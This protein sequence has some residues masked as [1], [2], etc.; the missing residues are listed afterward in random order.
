[1]PKKKDGPHDWSDPPTNWAEEQ[2]HRVALEI[3]RLR[4]KRP[5]QWLA[6]KTKELGSPVTRSVIS[7]M[8][9]GRRRYVT[10]A[11]LVIL[12]RAL[13]TAPIA[14]LY[15]APY[16]DRI[17]AL[18]TQD[19]GE[20]R[21]VEKITAVQW[22]SGEQPDQG[23][24]LD[25]L[26][27]SM[28]DQA[29]FHS[30]LLALDRARKAVALEQLRRRAVLRLDLTRQAKRD[31]R[32]DVTDDEIDELASVVIDYESRIDELVKLGD[33]DLVAESYDRLVG[34]GG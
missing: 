22:F 7:D 20:P 25:H 24:H 10:T 33:R 4:G 13:D 2:A 9:L 27:M 15:P 23:S 29:N 34:D 19:G 12:A 31:G 17:Q 11:E 3:R 14:L 21:E 26:G 16:W 1:M 18:P 8:E 6:D 5:V 30:Q 28:V 32:T